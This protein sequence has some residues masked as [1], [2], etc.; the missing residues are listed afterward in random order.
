MCGIAVITGEEVGLGILEEMIA[1]Q[2]HRGPD[3]QG[4]QLAD[5]SVGLGHSRLSIIDL[6]PSGHQPMSSADGRYWITFNGEIYNF[7][8]LRHELQGYPF[9]GHSDTEV[10]IAAFD[11]WGASCLNKLVGMFAFAVWDQERG[12]LFAARDRF[13]VKPLFFHRLPSG[14]LILASEIKAM[15]AV[16]VGRRPNPIAWST[17]FSFGLYDHSSMTFWNDIERVA[18]GGWLRWRRTCDIEQ[19][20]WYDPARVICAL[21]EDERSDDEVLTEA[22]ALFEESVRLRFRS[23]VPIGICLSGGLDSSLLTGLVRRAGP[24]GAAIEAF[25]FECGEPAYDESSWVE[26]MVAGSSHPWIR[27]RID[28]AG[29]PGRACSVQRA[30]DEPFGGIPTLGMAAVYEAARSRHVTVLLDAN[31]LDEAWG[32]YDYYA[33]ASRVDPGRGPVQAAI[34]PTVS[35]DCLTQSF[36]EAAEP[37]VPP[38]PFGDPLRDLQYRDIRYTKIPRATRFIDRNSMMHSIEVREPGLD[39]RLVE[40]GLRQPAS[41]KIRNGQGKWLLRKLAKYYLP[42]EICEAPKRS[43]QTPQREWL[44]GPL[45]DWASN[46]VEEGLAGWGRHWLEPSRVRESMNR[47]RVEQPDNSFLLWQWI[48]LGLMQRSQGE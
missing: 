23:D 15:H 40:L 30:Q 6:T 42:D 45:W 14:G 36:R 26:R 27:C 13:G 24:S 25:T 37:F 12:E 48:S 16:G 5:S 8:E 22:M 46:L 17:Y 10:L 2:L 31:G 41:R 11:R 7:I 47:Y 28:T 44:A 29:V 4:I 35:P 43:V 20:Q 1:S 33:R 9:R 34:S 32:G 21:G 3:D 19:G 18:P 39:H 38:S